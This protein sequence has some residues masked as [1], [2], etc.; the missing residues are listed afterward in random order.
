MKSYVAIATV[1]ICL[2]VDVASACSTCADSGWVER[3]EECKA[4]RG[5]GKIPNAEKKQCSRCFGT[6]KQTDSVRYQG[7]FCRACRGR[8]YYTDS[9]GLQCAR[10]EGTGV[11]V[12]KS[13][14][15]A[16]KGASVLNGID[17]TTPKSSDG[18]QNLVP[19]EICK[20]CD[21]KGN[22]TSK[23]TCELCDKG[24]NHEKTKQ[25]SFVCRNCNAQCDGRFSACKCGK[26]D[27]PQ[28]KGEYEKKT[29]ITCRFCGG[30]KIIT[31]LERE[32]TK[33]K[34]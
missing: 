32:K 12:S 7:T 31:P 29:S 28:C 13:V 22:I 6:G 21:E 27:C 9:V 1:S 5:T 34:E 11:K 26:S 20:A 14:C 25:G 10:C 30:D 3:R 16:C 4:C 15:H 19:V 17:Q 33:T 24:W 18:K 8:G 23:S 2:I